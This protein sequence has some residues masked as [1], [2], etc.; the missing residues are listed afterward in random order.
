M[1]SPVVL[2]DL[3]V[4]GSAD[5]ADLMLLR[6]GL[7]DY[8]VS[9]ALVRQIDISSLSPIPGGFAASTDLFM[10]SRTIGGNPQNFQI[11]FSQVGFS[12][13]T[14]A[15][16]WQAVA[17]VGWSIVPNTADRL[18]AVAPYF[19][20]TQGGQQSGTW[21]QNNHTLTIA[22]IPSHTHRVPSGKESAGSSGNPQYARR[23]RDLDNDSVITTESTG[24]GQGH[25]HGNVWRPL[26]N[27]G[28]ICNKDT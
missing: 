3:P 15:W 27:A 21:Q 9:V 12:K 23:A 14:R 5:N 4:A 8:Q 10:I 20:A 18:L 19:A 17:P 16:F 26:A 13:G 6:K 1:S 25:N 24:G 7:T 2:S 28:I 11:Q 22:E